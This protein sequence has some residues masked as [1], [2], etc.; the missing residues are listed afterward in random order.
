MD[1]DAAVAAVGGDREIFEMLV[2][3]SEADASAAGP[4]AWTDWRAT[5]LDQLAGAVRARLD[6]PTGSPVA[7]E[8]VKVAPPSVL[9]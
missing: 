7:A 5:L 8:A 1:V 3:L 2:A 9:T 6:A 4:L